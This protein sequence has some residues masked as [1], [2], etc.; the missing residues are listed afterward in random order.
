MFSLILPR[1]AEYELIRLLA[2]Y[3]SRIR[4]F[5]LSGK[6]DVTR[7][8]EEEAKERN[9]TIVQLQTVNQAQQVHTLLPAGHCSYS[10]SR[11]AHF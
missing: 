1:T 5:Q 11:K 9:E 8:L 6:N 2:R 4:L 3:S 10:N 7:R